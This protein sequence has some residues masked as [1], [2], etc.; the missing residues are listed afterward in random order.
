MGSKGKLPHPLALAPYVQDLSLLGM[1]VPRYAEF[2]TDSK[3]VWSV[4]GEL[5]PEDMKGLRIL[6]AGCNSGVFA[7]LCAKRGAE[8]L[9]ID[10]V[11]RYIAQAESIKAHLGFKRG[12]NFKRFSVY[13][14]DKLG[15]FDVILAL[16]LLY[17]L[18]FWLHALRK[19][20]GVAK[21]LIIIDTELLSTK[22]DTYQAR[23]ISTE[24][25]G[26]DTNWWIPG[27]G[28]IV[29]MLKSCGFSKIWALEVG[30]AYA[31]EEYTE[32]MDRQTLIPL[33]RRGLFVAV[34]DGV[35]VN[36]ILRTENL[37]G[38]APLE[39]GEEGIEYPAYPLDESDLPTR[40]FVEKKGERLSIG[41]KTE[42][43]LI[44]E[45]EPQSRAIVERD[46]KIAIG[47]ALGREGD[48]LSIRAL[49]YPLLLW[50]PPRSIKPEIS[51]EKSD[52]I[53]LKAAFEQA[54]PPGTYAILNVMCERLAAWKV[55]ASTA[56]YVGGKRS[57]QVELENIKPASWNIWLE[58]ILGV[59]FKKP[60][61]HRIRLTDK[62]IDHALL[63]YITVSP[64]QSGQKETGNSS[65]IS[66]KTFA[67]GDRITVNLGGMELES[68]VELIWLDRDLAPFGISQLAGSDASSA[69][70]FDTTWFPLGS[71]FLIV[72]LADG[73][74]RI[75]AASS[76]FRCDQGEAPWTPDA[77]DL[78]HAG[79]TFKK[80]IAPKRIS[81]GGRLKIAVEYEFFPKDIWPMIRVGLYRGGCDLVCEWD[82]WKGGLHLHHNGGHFI[83]DCP[84][85]PVTP[86]DY[87]LL[88]TVWHPTRGAFG[89]S[90]RLPLTVEEADGY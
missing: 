25:R 71:G 14:A 53:R 80:V 90:D 45:F 7:F 30:G 87:E 18:E 63:P 52:G 31:S 3:A 34:R 26:D 75:F 78:P 62:T 20:C 11:E 51:V 73:E 23:F 84:K 76:P 65:L 15:K 29:K 61:I 36:S 50:K 12:V 49:W 28:L 89:I 16:G 59:P 19:L 57:L 43:S 79:F 55:F 41:K 81:S 5:L 27:A 83:F 21:R 40:I 70:E 82:S 2:Q 6:E 66:P 74:Q 77:A 32:G 33:G 47:E 17:H 42:L 86:G 46:G 56:Y 8:V 68:A 37:G 85:L 64:A 39:M 88:I 44:D 72:N 60:Y 4:I 22:E 67:R 24:Y 35:D 9:G 13:E 48:R 69:L 54:M 58:L 10:V 38:F 1:D